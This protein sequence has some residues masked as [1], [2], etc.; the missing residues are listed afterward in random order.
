M[1]DQHGVCLSHHEI[2]DLVHAVGGAVDALRR[3]EVQAWAEAADKHWPAAEVTPRRVSVSCDG[4]LDCTNLREPRPEDPQRQR[5]Q[6]PQ[7]RVGCVSWQDD[8][9][10]WH[11]QM[12]W[13]R[14]DGQ[15]FGAS[16]YRL[17]CRCGDRQ[18]EERIFAADGGEWC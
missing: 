5:L 11:Q 10:T 4:I 2:L 17:A 7:M 12:I 3:A 8:D 14:E 13:G 9:E 1:F 6:W 18:A 15:A 16:R